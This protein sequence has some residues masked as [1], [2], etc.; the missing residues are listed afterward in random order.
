[1]SAI[2]AN[3]TPEKL[4]KE[5]NWIEKMGVKG[6]PT[7]PTEWYSESLYGPGQVNEENQL[8]SLV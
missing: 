8:Y 1:M 6:G 4:G 3:L 5:Q 7:N 2:E